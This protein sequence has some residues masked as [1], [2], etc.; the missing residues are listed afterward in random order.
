VEQVNETIRACAPSSCTCWW[1]QGW[2]WSGKK[3]GGR[4]Y[5]ANQRQVCP[6]TC[7]PGWPEP[8]AVRCRLWSSKTALSLRSVPT[9]PSVTAITV[10]T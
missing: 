9:A 10:S 3:R 2:G 4:G 6:C 7:G 1:V 8:S 5:F